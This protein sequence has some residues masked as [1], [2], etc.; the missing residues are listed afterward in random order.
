MAPTVL[1]CDANGCEF[2]TAGYEPAVAVELLKM[3]YNSQHMQVQ[4][5]P[6]A[7]GQAAP[8]VQTQLKPRAEKVPRPTLKLGVGQDEFSYFKD[9]W[10][11][12]KR[13]CDIT[14]EH[15]VRDQLRAACDEDLKLK[16]DLFSS[17]GSKLKTFTEPE[18]L[19]EIEK[20]AVLAQNNLVNVVQLLALTQDGEENVRAFLAR[21]KSSAS[22][23]DLSVT[24]TAHTCEENVS[25]A[26]KIILHALIRGLVDEE[27]REQVLAQTVEMSL[28]ETVK[29]IEPK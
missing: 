2:A 13:S 21:L 5:P 15:S 16:K 18:L 12:Y 7:A 24:C 9:N 4:P 26:D 27:I 17:C 14:D 29:F 23:C 3:H 25:Y 8:Q 20:L 22:V 10:E 11:L 6:Q 28:D 19:A 1:S